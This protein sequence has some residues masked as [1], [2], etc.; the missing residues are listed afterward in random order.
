MKFEGE[1]VIPAPREAVFE[2]INDPVFFASCID[3]VSDLREISP[4]E[5]EALLTTKLAFI[6]FRFDM[7]VTIIDAVAPSRIV[8]Q[9]TG[10]PRGMVGRL[11]ASAEAILS[12]ADGETRLSYAVDL[13]LAGKLGSIGQPVLRSKAKE[14]ERSFVKKASA[15]FEQDAEASRS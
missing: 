15:S 11:A 10:E 13:S 5:Y 4:T 6:N 12:D 2:R 7:S 8:A 1:F 14:M 3:G 9:A